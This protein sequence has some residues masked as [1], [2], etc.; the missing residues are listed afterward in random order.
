MS[1]ICRL[2]GNPLP[3]DRKGYEQICKDCREQKEMDNIE[4][5]CLHDDW[6]CRD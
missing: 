6:G 2:C 1:S 4:T 5:E 3:K